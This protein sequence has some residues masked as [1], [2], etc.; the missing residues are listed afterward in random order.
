[1]SAARDKV[2]AVIRDRCAAL[3]PAEQVD[4]ERGIFNFTLEDAKR[5]SIRCVW[6]N[7]E[8]QTL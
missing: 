7:P 4:L 3:T 2:R 8:F 1:M 6:E 5:R